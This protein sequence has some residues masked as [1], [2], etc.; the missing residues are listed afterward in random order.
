MSDYA[1]YYDLQNTDGLEVGEAL[2]DELYALDT[3]MVDDYEDDLGDA[4]V[5]EEE[6]LPD[7]PLLPGSNEAYVEHDANDGVEVR[8]TSWADD[9]DHS[10]FVAYLKDKI[11]RI[12]RWSGKTVPGAERALAYL[13]ACE[14]EISK[15]MRSDLDG[16][17][18]Q[19]YNKP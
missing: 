5:V 11:T 18:A 12:P 4:V 15:A 13:K 9:G 6:P 16:K 1:E 8:E 2:A 17:V 7:V 19:S 10:K 14:Q 3:L